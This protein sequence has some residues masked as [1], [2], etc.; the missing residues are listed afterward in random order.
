MKVITVTLN[1]SLDRPMIVNHLNVG[2][3]NYAV[4]DTQLQ[5]AGRGMNMA[6]ALH[7][8]NTDVTALVLLGN[9]PFSAAYTTLIQNLGFPVH[10]INSQSRIR[11]NLFIV[12]EANETH[13]VIKE[14][15][16]PVDSESFHRLR[17]KLVTCI[18][19]EDYL[20]FP[21]SLPKDADTD[22]YAWLTKAAQEAGGRVILHTEDDILREA[23]KANPHMIYLRQL[24]AE[25][26]FNFPVRVQSDV[27]YCAEKL[28]EA[29][30]EN[31]LVVMDDSNFAVLAEGGRSWLI[32]LAEGESFGTRTGML[33]A[34]IAGYLTGQVKER[35]IE[36]ALEL[37]AASAGY[38]LRQVGADFA[39]VAD[40]KANFRGVSVTRIQHE[41]K[42]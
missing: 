37:G 34:F 40:L 18:E 32:E 38:V 28:V 31:A 30:T 27:I 35:K 6:K 21:G 8:L 1:P 25:S 29:G 19:A 7:G 10:I 12:D 15:S 33:E 11:S 42:G 24:Q 39:T 17:D 20:V 3:H 26:Y 36:R 14:D 5:A 41:E 16:E 13:T 9:D 22:T 2:Y 23:L 4:G